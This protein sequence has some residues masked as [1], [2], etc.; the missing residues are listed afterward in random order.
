MKHTTDQVRAISEKVYRIKLAESCGGNDPA[1]RAAAADRMIEK[2][3]DG[4]A[5][6]SRFA[7]QLDAT[8]RVYLE[9]LGVEL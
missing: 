7:G 2:H 3:G 1:W 6:F 5:K 4:G 8:T 9:V